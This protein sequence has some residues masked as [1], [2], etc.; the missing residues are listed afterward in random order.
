MRNNTFMRRLQ[1]AGVAAEKAQSL[2]NI[3]FRR[4]MQDEARQGFDARRRLI[5]TFHAVSLSSSGRHYA[6]YCW[7][8]TLRAAHDAEIFHRKSFAA[9]I[10]WR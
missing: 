5:E 3:I 8:L 7:L 2:I 9:F 1:G 10:G 6:F 4:Q